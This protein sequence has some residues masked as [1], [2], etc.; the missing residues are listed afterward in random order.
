MNYINHGNVP[1]KLS[2]WTNETDGILPLNATEKVYATVT[3]KN[4]EKKFSFL[5]WNKNVS[6]IGKLLSTSFQNLDSW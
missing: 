3:V 1:T 4:K 2:W 5:V 6:V